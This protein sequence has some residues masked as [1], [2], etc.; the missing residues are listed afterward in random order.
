[1]TP[2][3]AATGIARIIVVA[4]L[5]AGLAGAMRTRGTTDKTHPEPKQTAQLH[6]AHVPGYKSR[7]IE[8][9]RERI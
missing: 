9:R 3:S 6:V 1:M 7:R 5:I 4:S 8:I 2:R